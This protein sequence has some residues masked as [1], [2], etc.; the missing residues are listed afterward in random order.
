MSDIG[1]AYD[2]IRAAYAEAAPDFYPDVFDVSTPGAVT[3]AGDGTFTEG[4]TALGGVPGR[5]DP[6]SAYERQ[7]SVGAVGGFADYKLTF[8][9][10]FAGAPLDVPAPA[11]ATVRARGVNPALTFR[12]VG[13]LKSSSALKLVVAA[14]LEG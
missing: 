12:V 9:Y 8:P 10:F 11:T 7:A 6:M 4:V 1:A 5:Y 13:P 2:E 3:N 14:K